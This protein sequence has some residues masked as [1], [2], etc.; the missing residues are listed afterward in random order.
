MRELGRGPVCAVG[1]G[2]PDERGVVDGTLASRGAG[3]R[4]GVLAEQNGVGFLEARVKRAGTEIRPA[5]RSLRRVKLI[6]FGFRDQ[7]PP[8]TQ[9]TIDG[10][11]LPNPHRRLA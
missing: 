3:S 4:L 2:E 1:V 10:R 8:N 6:S 11:S 9:V 5:N 7:L